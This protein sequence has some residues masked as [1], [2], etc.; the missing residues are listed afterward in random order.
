MLFVWSLRVFSLTRNICDFVCKEVL[1]LF[2]WL[3]RDIN[4]LERG[5][6]IRIFRIIGNKCL[7]YYYFWNP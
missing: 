1:M 3:L 7:I 5:Y 2:V 4:L 6:Y